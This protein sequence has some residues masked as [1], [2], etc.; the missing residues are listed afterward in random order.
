MRHDDY[1][2][3]VLHPSGEV[4]YLVL[5]NY[6]CQHNLSVSYCCSLFSR[7]A[8][9]VNNIRPTV[10]FTTFATKSLTYYIVREK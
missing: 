7:A 9:V 6:F 10:L 8:K 2:L 3:G 4:V 5:S 1:L